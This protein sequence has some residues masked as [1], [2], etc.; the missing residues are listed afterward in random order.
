MAATISS[1]FSLPSGQIGSEQQMAMCSILQEAVLTLCQAN[2]PETSQ[3]EVDAIICISVLNSA[4]QHVVKI[5]EKLNDNFD[6]M[7]IAQNQKSSN[8][9]LGKRAVCGV[10]NQTEEGKVRSPQ[11]EQPVFSHQLTRQNRRA[12]GRTRMANIQKRLVDSA[13]SFPKRSKTDTPS[14]QTCESV[15]IKTE[16]QDDEDSSKA[17]ASI[18]NDGT[19]GGS[20]GEVGHPEPH[21]TA[22]YRSDIPGEPPDKTTQLSE[23]SI[24]LLPT[25]PTVSRRFSQSNQFSIGSRNV[26]STVTCESQAQSADSAQE[27]IDS[28]SL[29]DTHM[30]IIPLNSKTELVSHVDPDISVDS[31]DQNLSQLEMVQSMEEQYL[32]S[33]PSNG[34]DDVEELEDGQEMK[35]EDQA[36][37]S[38]VR[39]HPSFYFQMSK[40]PGLSDQVANHSGFQG[41]LGVNRNYFHC[42]SCG[43]MFTTLKSRNRHETHVCTKCSYTCE[44]CGK[45]FSRMDNMKRH[46]WKFHE[47]RY[48]Q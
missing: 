19:Q 36:E 31:S 7:Y 38:E 48:Y 41:T 35:Y 4:E 27:I 23:S 2:Y 25:E 8:N 22:L 34:E 17:S 18:I 28:P 16:P 6:P 37:A 47:N 20:S 5:H 13:E 44:I 29:A 1:P 26:S 15:R 10:T 9:L 40:V 39:L 42:R 46:F 12:S 3:L 21:P 32:Q 24:L 14:N 45:M 11:I 43:A 30:P 33:L